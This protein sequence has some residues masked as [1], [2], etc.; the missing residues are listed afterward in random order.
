MSISGN[1]L[2]VSVAD[3]MQFIHLGGRT[4]T[5][6]IEAKGEKAEVGFHRGRIISALAPTSKR[7]GDLLLEARVI[8]RDN[9]EAALVRQ[10][11]EMP[12]MSLGKI[13]VTMGLV[14][15]DRLRE[16]VTEQIEL[17]VYDLVAW[18]EGQFQFAMDELRP[19]DDIAV[20]PGDILPDINLNTQI[21]VL[22]AL[23]IF[24]EKNRDRLEDK[25]S[26]SKEE[27]ANEGPGIGEPQVA[28]TETQ[29]ELEGDLALASLMGSEEGER[30]GAAEHE[31][32]KATGQ[33]SVRV[34][35]VS[36]DFELLA[37]LKSLSGGEI[38]EVVGVRLWDAGLT[39]PGES[40][41]VV[42]VD[43]RHEA[44]GID[45]LEGFR[46]A[47]AHATIVALVDENNPLAGV[48]QAG[49]L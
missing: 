2:D 41:P 13:L 23:R 42:L 27:S 17:T 33:K 40:P 46:R 7:L 31:D 48:Y 4:G 9:L 32:W 37:V 34:Q 20:Y 15:K 6:V 45:E 25:D 21:V 43:L 12:R 28:V 24:D 19:I 39:L 16:V 26:G 11:A 10:Q 49:A 14:T 44:I 8:D 38:G 36:P 3:V 47:R 22:E 30:E 29:A 1:L 18:S 5:L 35:I